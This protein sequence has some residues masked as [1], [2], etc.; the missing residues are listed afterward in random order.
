MSAS[1]FSGSGWGLALLALLAALALASRTAWRE[2]CTVDEFGNLPLTIAY[3]QP[4]TLHIDRGN[5]P[6][7]RWLQGLPF[8]ANSPPLGATTAE[9]ERIETSWDLGYRFEAVHHEDYHALLAKARSVSVG[10]LLLTVLGVF[11]WARDLAG[12]QGAFAAALLAAFSPNLLAHGRLVTPDIGLACFVVWAGWAAHRARSTLR[13]GA[14]AATGIL[15]AGACLAKFSGLLLLPALAVVLLTAKSSWKRRLAMLCVFVICALALMYAGTGSIRP[16][17]FHSW[18]TPLPAGYVTGIETQLTEPPYPAY[19]FGEVREGGW[20]WYYVVAFLMK[21]PLPVL[22]L[23]AGATFVI[24]RRR[25]GAFALPLALA[26]AFFVAF[27]FVTKKNVGLRYLLPILPLLHVACAVLFAPSASKTQP[28]G[29]RR[30]ARVVPSLLVVVA[31][32]VGT[33][34]SAAPLASFNGLQVFFGG[35]RHVLVDSNLDWGQALP[36]LRDWMERE[37]VETIRLAYFGRIDPSIY[38]IRWRSLPAEP[39]ED[40]CAISATLAVGR[41]YVV[42]WKERPFE[43]PTLGWSTAESWRWTRD[44]EP[45]EELGGGAI[46]VWRRRPHGTALSLCATESARF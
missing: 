15:T 29:D 10:L 33:L 23:V 28:E 13:W 31:L 45:D 6:L 25:R 16:G 19:L 42:R 5:P 18:P 46:L 14:V 20:P 38:G 2:S 7:T 32:I 3:W 27:G 36:D 41:P 43:E 12:R 21:V 8:V 40:A 34:A 9:L 22:A 4:G 30:E 37:G 11:V 1:R 35:K 26:G 17:F 39:V 44:R 24:V